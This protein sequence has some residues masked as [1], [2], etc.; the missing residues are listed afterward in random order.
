[1][2]AENKCEMTA[3]LA[4]LPDEFREAAGRFYVLPLA[5]KQALAR[6]VDNYADDIGRAAAR[7]GDLDI[8]LADCIARCCTALLDEEWD[9]AD[10]SG[11]RLIQTACHYF[12]ESDDEDGD[13]ESVYGFDDDA[14]LLNEILRLLNRTDLALQI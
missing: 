13:L 11:K 8:N 1:M 3:T 7:R 14:E 5:S 4:S 12:V 9:S 2:K 6:M 10:D